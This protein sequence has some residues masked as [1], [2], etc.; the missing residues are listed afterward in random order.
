MSARSRIRRRPRPELTGWS[1]EERIAP[2]GAIAFEQRAHATR[3]LVEHS[4]AG[5]LALGECYWGEVEAATHRL[6][7][8]RARGDRVELRLL[9]CT[10]L[11]FAPAQVLVERGV[12]TSRF[13]IDG[14]LLA[15]TPAGSISFSQ[16]AGS[17]VVLRATIDGFF[18]RL[19][20]RPGAPAWTGAL[21]QH[22]QRRLHTAIS[23]RYF[24][25]L[26]GEE[27]T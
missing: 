11:R 5:A 15:R 2:T 20:G 10:L 22:L 13:P 21:Y 6:V 23:R 24:H 17:P 25:R 9:G 18:P 26:I 16:T 8:R 4:E 1:S 14:G 12:V 19:A 3:E 27:P 7:R